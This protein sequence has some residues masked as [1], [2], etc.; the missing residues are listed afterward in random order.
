MKYTIHPYDH[1]IGGET[2]MQRARNL[3][4]AKERGFEPNSL[5]FQSVLF[6]GPL[7]LLDLPAE[8][9]HFICSLLRI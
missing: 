9:N 7:G 6:T 8:G 2:K 4:R 5:I 1:I 3:T